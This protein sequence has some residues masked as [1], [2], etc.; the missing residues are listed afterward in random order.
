MKA[1]TLRQPWAW[2][3]LHGTRR[4]ETRPSD[5][6]RGWRGVVALHAA[7]T[8]DVAG[9][10]D[11]RVLDEI[12]TDTAND[13]WPMMPVGAFVGLAELVDVHPATGCCSPWGDPHGF[14]LILEDP[15]PLQQ[16][17]GYGRGH[18][19]LWTPRAE[20]VAWINS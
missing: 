2:V 20:A 8:V 4:V 12:P 13:E 14:H 7:L 18:G 15:R 1:I 6:T 16:P 5:P 3:T 17:V 9:M 11:P 19:G 10:R